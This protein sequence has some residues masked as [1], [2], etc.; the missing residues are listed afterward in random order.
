MKA[1]LGK[2]IGMTQVFTQDGIAVPV[3]VVKAGPCVVVQKKTAETDGYSA[4]QLGFGEI[5]AK[6]VNKPAAGHFKKAGADA[7]RT[8]REIRTDED[9]QVGQT[10]RADVFAEG[11]MVDVSGISKGHGFT[12]V[13]QQIPPMYSALKRQGQPL[14]KLARKGIEVER[15]PREVTIHELRLLRLE[16]EELDVLHVDQEGPRAVLVARTALIVVPGAFDHDGDF[17]AAVSGADH[18]VD[19]RPE[20]GFVWA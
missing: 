19:L 5:K 16:G 17:R 3:T 14:Y 18:R 2:K 6:N 11:E 4:L 20:H 15:E 13:I 1:I 10:I 7:L 12:G 8:L 9:A